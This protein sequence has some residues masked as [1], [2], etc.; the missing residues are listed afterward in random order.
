MHFPIDISYYER[1]YCQRQ[2]L[3]QEVREEYG[4]H[5]TAVVVS[6]VGK[7]VEW[8]NQD[9]IIEAL[10]LLEQKGIYIHLFIIGSGTMQELW[11]QKSMSLKKSKVYFTGFVKPEKLPGYYAATDIYIHPAAIEP[12]SLAISEAIYMGC[13][14]IISDRC[15]S[16]GKNDDVQ[17]DKNGYVFQFGKIDDLAKKIGLL[18]LAPEIRSR[19][20]EYSHFIAVEF[21][22]K[23]HS[24]FINELI[25][26]L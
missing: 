8:K 22:K 1:Y 13:P 12:H 7:L 5:E 20:G 16:Y 6:V 11:Q 26:R 24:Y 10:Q 21:Q 17:I 25:S 18:A 3:C 23:A 19:F 4:I 2:Q 15:G 9:D 14:V